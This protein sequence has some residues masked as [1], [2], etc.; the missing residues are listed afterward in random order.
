MLIDVSI[1]IKMYDIQAE[2]TKSL[3]NQLVFKKFEKQTKM[4]LIV[5]TSKKISVKIMKKYNKIYWFLIKVTCRF[6]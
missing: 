1:I 5:K 6:N 2:Y 3:W 4:I